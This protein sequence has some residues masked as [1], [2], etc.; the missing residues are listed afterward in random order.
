MS[1]TS[2]NIFINTL[3]VILVVVM[4]WVVI[5]FFLSQRDS[6]GFE[7]INETHVCG[8]GGIYECGNTCSDPY[9]WSNF[10]ADLVTFDNNKDGVI[11]PSERVLF[12]LALERVEVCYDECSSVMEA[13]CESTKG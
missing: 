1:E 8:V 2:G 6:G 4:L 12:E 5:T 9:G 3:L 10:E 11:S 7:G 13:L